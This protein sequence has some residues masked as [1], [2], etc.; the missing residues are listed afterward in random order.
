[1]SD[2]D[3]SGYDAEADR[4]RIEN[5]MLRGDAELLWYLQHPN[6]VVPHPET[7]ASNRQPASGQIQRRRT[8]T[9]PRRGRTRRRLNPQSDRSSVVRRW[10]PQILQILLDPAVAGLLDRKPPHQR[11][12]LLPKTIRNP[13]RNRRNNLARLQAGVQPMV[14]VVRGALA[15]IAIGVCSA[16]AAEQPRLPRRAVAAN[17]LEGVCRELRGRP[18][19][20]RPGPSRRTARCANSIRH[21]LGRRTEPSSA[22]GLEVSRRRHVNRQTAV[23]APPHENLARCSA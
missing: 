11:A 10:S 8:A 23:A 18:T 12:V 19:A 1:M 7:K 13:T 4:I 22:R 15:A 9:R 17:R 20:V 6:Q 2:R 21:V 5:I 3:L 16:W 14:F